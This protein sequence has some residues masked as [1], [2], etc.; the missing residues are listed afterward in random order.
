M[1]SVCNTV[2]A[3]LLTML[4]SV[5]GKQ[6][7]CALS[8]DEV[9]PPLKLHQLYKDIAGWWWQTPLILALGRQREVDLC[10]FKANLGYRSTSR[11]ARLHKKILYEDMSEWRGMSLRMPWAFERQCYLGSSKARESLE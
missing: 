4:S 7:E 10:E 2:E 6:M 9:L 8:S 5:T 3:I 1:L 11:T